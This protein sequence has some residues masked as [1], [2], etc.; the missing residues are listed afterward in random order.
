ML[1]IDDKLY[2]LYTNIDVLKHIKL[3]RLDRVRDQEDDT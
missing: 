2:K 3:M 1:S